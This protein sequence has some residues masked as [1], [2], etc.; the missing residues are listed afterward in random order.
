MW[1][2]N[3]GAASAYAALR[4]RA[5]DSFKEAEQLR[6]LLHTAA[7]PSSLLGGGDGM[8]LSPEGTS[9]MERQGGEE[10][11]REAER[12]RGPPTERAASGAV[13]QRVGVGL[14]GLRNG[15]WEG[16][17]HA[18]RLGGREGGVVGPLPISIPQSAQPHTAPLA[19][20]SAGGPLR[21][22]SSRRGRERERERERT[23]LGVGLHEDIFDWN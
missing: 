17:H 22:R 10:R 16:Y 23:K 3:T 21:W 20:R 7:Q 15:G 12:A 11:G 6:E 1:A 5:V 14:G 18:W 2:A 19:D 8:H 13:R 9:E 4:R